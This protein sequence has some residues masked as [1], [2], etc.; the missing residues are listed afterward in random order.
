MPTSSPAIQ[1]GGNGHDTV[2]S[3]TVIADTVLSPVTLNQHQWFVHSTTVA[4]LDTRLF[5][6][7]ESMTVPRLRYP[8]PY[9]DST[10]Q[11]TEQSALAVA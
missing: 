11:L 6:L 1:S 5:A 4:S 7:T 8:A 3:D 2:I 10:C 9:P